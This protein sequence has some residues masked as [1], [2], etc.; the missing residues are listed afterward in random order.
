MYQYQIDLDLSN[1]KEDHLKTKSFVGSNITENDVKS[2]LNNILNKYKEAPSIDL[3]IE[4]KDNELNHILNNIESMI[5]KNLNKTSN[6]L[7]NYIIKDENLNNTQINIIENNNHNLKNYNDSMQV[8]D[9][10]I[11]NN[12]YNNSPIYNQ[13]IFQIIEV[14]VLENLFL[15][16]NKRN[17]FQ[18]KTDYSGSFYIPDNYEIFVYDPFINFA[19]NSMLNDAYNNPLV[20]NPTEV[21]RK[22]LKTN[23]NLNLNNSKDIEKDRMNTVN[24]EDNIRKINENDN[25]LDY[26]LNNIDENKNNEKDIVNITNSIPKNPPAQQISFTSKRNDIKKVEDHPEN[27]YIKNKNNN[28]N[29]ELNTNKIPKSSNFKKH[30]SRLKWE[31]GGGVDGAKTKENK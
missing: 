18:I 23:N 24:N 16:E 27:R 11:Q 6:E 9:Y 17:K 1:D 15:D 14:D 25:D 5:T 12:N 2:K 13:I 3:K 20:N 31:G 28:I 29:F 4:N 26:Y 19:F 8:L 21:N 7:D 30:I 22:I 10:E